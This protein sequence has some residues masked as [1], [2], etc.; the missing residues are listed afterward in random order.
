MV[1]DV[2]AGQPV[3]MACIVCGWGGMVSWAEALDWTPHID[4]DVCTECVERMG[5]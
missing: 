5:R 2:Q 1:T 4:G 3:H